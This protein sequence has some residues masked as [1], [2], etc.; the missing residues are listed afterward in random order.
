M[1]TNGSTNA[2]TL[3]TSQNAT[4]A[5]TAT[6]AGGTC[7]GSFTVSSTEP[8]IYLTDTNNNS[9]F[10]IRN[11]DGIFRIF[12]STNTRNC[13]AI[14]SSGDTTFAGRVKVGDFIETSTTNTN[15]KINSGGSSGQIK[16]YINE[17]EKAKL[18]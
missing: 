8:R 12:D 10:E 1:R 13:L 18:D 3:D 14:D 6:F 4:F 15:L 16:F 9:D 5:G 17:S 11:V 2:L 7:N